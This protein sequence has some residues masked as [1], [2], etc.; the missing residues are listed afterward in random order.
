[1]SGSKWWDDLDKVV[2]DQRRWKGPFMFLAWFGLMPL[3]LLAIM[4]DP[5]SDLLG[6]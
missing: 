1:M 4:L 2:M 5:L 6:D 3:V